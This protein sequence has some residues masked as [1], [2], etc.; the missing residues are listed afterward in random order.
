MSRDD[1]NRKIKTRKQ[2]TAVGKYSFVHRIIK[3]WNQLPVNLLASFPCN[4]NAFRKMVK[5]AVTSKGFQVR[6]ER[7]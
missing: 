7:K 1:H 6:I 5:K 3:S 4:L 2:R